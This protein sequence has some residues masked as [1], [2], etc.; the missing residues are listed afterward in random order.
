MRESIPEAA[1]LGGRA[2]TPIVSPFPPNCVFREE[3]AHTIVHGRNDDG[4][5]PGAIPAGATPTKE[6]CYV[7]SEDRVERCPAVL[8]RSMKT[9][10]SVRR[11]EILRPSAGTCGSP[12][13]CTDARPPTGD[14]L[15]F[16][17]P[18]S[19]DCPSQQIPPPAPKEFA[20]DESPDRQSF[21]L[22]LFVTSWSV[23]RHAFFSSHRIVHERPR[24]S[25]NLHQ[26]G[27]VTTMI[28]RF[29]FPCFAFVLLLLSVA[30]SATAAP[31]QCNGKS[32]KYYE[33]SSPWLPDYWLCIS[34]KP[35][36]G[37]M[38]CTIL[39]DHMNCQSSSVPC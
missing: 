5:S 8:T 16:T 27:R 1:S 11:N 19:P 21:F 34:L 24:E 6:A 20:R 2:I 22:A 10:G 3:V 17:F 7:R 25:P 9:H 29:A 36:E 37:L 13:E 15:D 35:G 12:S 31:S 30:T 32:C 23:C 14:G 38:H 33:S 18:S 39:D 28:K 4:G 26:N